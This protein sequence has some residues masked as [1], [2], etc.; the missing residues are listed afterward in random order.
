AMVVRVVSFG[1]KYGLPV[2]AELVFDLRY[3]P[4]PH[5]VPEL[6]PRPGTDPGVAGYVLGSPETQALLAQLVP[7]FESLLPQYEQEGK[8]YL[9]LALGCTGGRHRSVALAEEIGRR[10]GVGRQVIVAHR[11]VERTQP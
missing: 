7:L 3:L 11:D 1:Y 9:T 10:L 6:K 5:F 8:A 4:N 2:D